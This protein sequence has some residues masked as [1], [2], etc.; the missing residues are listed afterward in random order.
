[1][2]LHQEAESAETEA[3]AIDLTLDIL[4]LVPLYGAIPSASHAIVD[5][6]LGRHWDAAVNWVGAIPGVA[7]FKYFR[8]AEK[9]A[10]LASD[11]GKLARMLSKVKAWWNI[12]AK[13]DRAWS[14]LSL[15]DKVFHEIGNKT[16]I[17]ARFKKY[18]GLG[19][20]AAGRAIV[21]DY[22]W[23][24]AILPDWPGLSLGLLG[25]GTRTFWT[26]PTAAVRGGYGVQIA[27]LVVKLW[28]WEWHGLT[29]A[30]RSDDTH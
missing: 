6:L 23:L 13:G 15:L 19:K 28:V 17:V 10:E 3:F 25:K 4:S 29:G 12:G 24:V 1:M 7:F 9:A 14:E 21:R 5:H 18:E 2:R 30:R 8:R 22:G 26:G 27:V 11:S 16:Q 20:V